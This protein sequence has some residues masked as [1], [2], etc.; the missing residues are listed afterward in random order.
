MG[1]GSLDSQ[2]SRAVVQQHDRRLR[3]ADRVQ[4][5]RADPGEA[6]AWPALGGG[7]RV[8]RV[9]WADDDDSLL[10]GVLDLH[11]PELPRKDE[12]STAGLAWRGDDP[13]VCWCDD[14]LPW[15]AIRVAE[16]LRSDAGWA[17]IQTRGEWATLPDAVEAAAELRVEAAGVGGLRLMPD[18][19]DL[20]LLG[21]AGHV[22]LELPHPAWP[23]VLVLAG[24]ENLWLPSGLQDLESLIVRDYGVVDARIVATLPKLKEL[25]IQGAGSLK[26]LS[27]LDALTDLRLLMIDQP[28]VDVDDLPSPEALERL[29]EVWVRNSSDEIRI[30]MRRRFAQAWVPD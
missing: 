17:E 21:D 30:A 11:T 22:T 10:V 13:D 25:R 7:Y 26:H 24:G 3:R 14:R 2:F 4:R 23:F 12:V 28:H 27:A 19:Q 29:D 15:W 6:Y 8:A 18:V 9:L 16:G 5:R 1:S 20:W